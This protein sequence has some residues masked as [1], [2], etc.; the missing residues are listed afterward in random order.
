[1]GWGE[2]SVEGAAADAE[3]FCDGGFG[4]AVMEPTLKVVF[5]LIGEG[6]G[7]SSW[8]FFF[9]FGDGDAFSLAFFDE[10]AFEFCEGS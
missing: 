10:G 2:L 4:D 7:F 8:V 5:L 6:D 9:S 3:S 1:M